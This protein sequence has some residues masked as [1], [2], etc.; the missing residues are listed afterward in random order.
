MLQQS[1]PYLPSSHVVSFLAP[2]SSKGQGEAVPLMALSLLQ[3][4]IMAPAIPRFI[5]KAR[6][7]AGMFL[8]YSPK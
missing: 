6:A 3:L 4:L 8:Y 5:S 2:E 7:D 1:H